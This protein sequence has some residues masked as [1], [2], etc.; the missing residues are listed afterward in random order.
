[1]KASQIVF[2]KRQFSTQSI[3]GALF[4]FNPIKI[5]I[6]G[7]DGSAVANEAQYYSC[8]LDIGQVKYCP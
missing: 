7:Y 3:H 8:T 4:G 5:P 2:L 1:M 6:N